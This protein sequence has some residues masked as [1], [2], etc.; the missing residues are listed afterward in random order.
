MIGATSHIASRTSAPVVGPSQADPPRR[1][2]DPL[3]PSANTSSE[4][5]MRTW[6]RIG[7][8]VL[9]LIV[10]FAGLAAWSIEDTYGHGLDFSL[11]GGNVYEAGV[12]DPVFE[13][14]PQEARDYMERR[15]AAV[16]RNFVVPGLI[17]ALG[18]VLVIAAFLPWQR[19]RGG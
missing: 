19:L 14:S 13:G 16:E 3:S 7:L 17:V 2:I 11:R 5:N 9:G 1:A 6:H 15:R 12:Q 10:L 8:L 4:V 18:V